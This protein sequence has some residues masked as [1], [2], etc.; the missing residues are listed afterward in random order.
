MSTNTHTQSEENA[1]T[2][3]EEFQLTEE[4]LDDLTKYAEKRAKKWDCP[5]N[6]EIDE[7]GANPRFTITFL[8]RDTETEA[9]I[10]KL[11]R[12]P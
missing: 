5:I 7:R 3:E 2:R 11:R 12:Y 8:V 9:G 6:V 1:H 10:K 4:F